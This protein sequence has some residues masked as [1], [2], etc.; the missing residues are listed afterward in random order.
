MYGK[1]RLREFMRGNHRQ[2]AAEM[3]TALQAEL[4]E[5]SGGGGAQDDV[6]FVVVRLVGMA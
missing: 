1:D 3:A 6:T 4:A 2:S 5:F